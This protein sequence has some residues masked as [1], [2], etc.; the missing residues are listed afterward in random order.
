[1]LSSLFS[2]VAAWRLPSSLAVRWPDRV[3]PIRVGRA[4]HLAAEECVAPAVFAGEHAGQMPFDL[5]VDHL[6]YFV[7]AL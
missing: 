2:R 7:S 4:N 6:A 3:R 1:M 5:P